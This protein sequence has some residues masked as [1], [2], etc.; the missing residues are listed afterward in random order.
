MKLNALYSHALIEAQHAVV[1]CREN[2][3]GHHAHVL[4][5]E[6]VG[7]HSIADLKSTKCDTIRGLAKGRNA[8]ASHL[9]Q[10]KSGH[11]RRIAVGE[12]DTRWVVAIPDELRVA[13]WFGMS[14]VSGENENPLK[15]GSNRFPNFNEHVA[16]WGGRH[17]S[18]R[19]TPF[20]WCWRK[21]AGP[22]LAITGSL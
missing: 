4:L 9:K 12:P 17:I 11:N 3:Q 10:F 14:A 13:I 8:E 5:K 20:R 22:P 15:E 7:R 2:R 19:S 18:L 1:R 6:F 21:C 16:D